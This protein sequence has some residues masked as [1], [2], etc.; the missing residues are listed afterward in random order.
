MNP[1][2]KG[3]IN[4]IIGTELR[5]YKGLELGEF[6]LVVGLAQGRFSTKGTTLS[7]FISK[8]P[9]RF[10]GAKGEVSRTLRFCLFHERGGKPKKL[11]RCFNIQ[12]IPFQE[13]T[14]GS[15]VF[16]R[17]CCGVMECFNA[18]G[19]GWWLMHHI[20]KGIVK[21]KAPF[22]GIYCIKVAQTLPPCFGHP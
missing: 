20:R 19:T 22:L 18:Q 2:L 9:R 1:S 4:C 12:I 7:S 10:C 11:S 21:R 14:N 15:A 17:G 13:L 16:E 6:C 8:I 5:Q 3:F